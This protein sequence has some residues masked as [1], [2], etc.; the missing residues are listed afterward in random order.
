MRHCGID[1]HARTCELCEVSAR[2]KVIR[3]E[4]LAATEAGFRRR[5]K[6]AP[7]TRV[8][9][10]CCGSSPWIVRLLESLGHEVV[11]VNPRRV[12]LIAES[13]LKCDRVDA[14]ILARLSRLGP[15]MLHP[16]YQRSYEGQLLRT[17]LRLRSSLV[18]ARGGLINQ[19]RGTLRAHGSPMSSCAAKSFVARFATTG[20]PRHLREVLE[21]LVGAIGELTDRIEVLEKELVEESHSDELLERLQEVPGVGPLVSLSFVGWV[22]RAERFARS[23]DVGAS[24]GLRPRLR[25]SGGISRR[26]AITREGDTNMRWLL[27]QAAHAALAVR[28]DSALKRW[29]EALVNRVGKKRAVVALARKLGVLLHTLWVTGDSYRPFPAAA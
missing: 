25:E 15:E 12:R 1:V 5:F 22:D 24:L 9:M 4:R 18:R 8:V 6:A 13:T 10:E 14:E 11:V 23:R 20:P 17:R 27:V 2:G 7:R 3:R 29:A 26:G 28:R 21:P 19:V 16:V